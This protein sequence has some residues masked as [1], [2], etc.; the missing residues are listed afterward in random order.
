M[1]VFLSQQRYMIDILK[2][3][4]MLDAK[5]VGTPMAS[6]TQFSAYEGELFLDSTLFLY[7]F[8]CLAV[9]VHYKT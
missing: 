8:G 2:R 9:F 1:G 7:H 4:N 6:S 3:T 5:P